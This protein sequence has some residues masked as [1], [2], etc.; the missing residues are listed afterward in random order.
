MLSK[1]HPII[2]F[3]DRTGFSLYQDILG[4]V[5]KFNF[6][7]DL[8]SNLDIVDKE[9]FTN[10]ITTFM[11]L[12]KV[13][14]SSMA[15]VLSD[16]VVCIKD[17]VD[18]PVQKAA[19]D[20][21]QKTSVSVDSNSAEAQEFL[22]NIPFENVLSKVV[23]AGNSSRAVAVNEDLIT[24]I[25]DVFSNAG[26][27]LETIVP[28]FMF[29]QN[30]N[31]AVGLTL[32]NAQLI[33]NNPEI[34][35]SGNLLTE[36]EKAIPS[37][38]ITAEI[39]NSLKNSKTDSSIKTKKTNNARQYILIAILI[40][41]LIILAIVY[42]AANSKS[43]K[44]NNVKKQNAVV[45]VQVEPTIVVTPTTS[46]IA[47]SAIPIVDPGSVNV[48]IMSSSQSAQ[49]ALALK[50]GIL[51]MGYKNVF[52]QAS[53]VLVPEKSTIV[54]SQ[55]IPMDMKSSII[56]EIRKAM[57]TVVILDDQNSKNEINISIGKS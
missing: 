12:N 30:A 1:S 31:F 46:P 6:T 14:P 52:D 24:T 11:Q 45:A 41:L 5:S 55:N 54:F 29:G 10:L 2:I 57:P 7:L 50:S 37:G 19:S 43:V 15:V 22:E 3:I 39:N 49:L 26:S 53:E 42:F 35:R 40:V 27:V 48:K 25:T 13:I 8:V 18:N 33:L 9:K 23:K 4:S 28:G 20:S 32:E 17:L 47:S 44:S 16:G 51:A 34:L 36:K 21:I 56:A 38:G